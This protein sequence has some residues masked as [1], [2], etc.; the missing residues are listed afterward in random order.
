MPDMR[1]HLCRVWLSLGEGVS[2]KARA[3]ILTSF[4][5]YQAAFDRFPHGFDELVSAK[6]V[7]ELGRLK[8]AG[9]DRLAL[10][11]EELGIQTA[12]LGDEAEYP[13]MLSHIPDPPDVLFYRGRLSGGEE[14]A[15]AIVGSRR[16]T[17]YGRNQAYRIALELAQHGVTVISGLARGIDTAAH[18][19]ALDGKGR[20]IAVLGSGLSR[21]YPEENK[22]LA[23]EIVASGGA[24]VTELSPNTEPLAY[25]FP[26]RNRIV[27]G[28]SQAVLLVEAR[29]KSGTLI[30]VGHALDQGR[31]V[32]A[33]PGEVDAPGSVIP[34]RVIRT[35]GRLCTCAG[36]ILE[37][38]GW[39]EA[40]PTPPEQTRLPLPDLPPAQQ[41]TCRALQDEE[42][43]FDELIALTEL[44]TAELNTALTMLE[45]DGL[46]EPLPGRQFK[47]RRRPL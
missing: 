3:R 25:H 17:R 46:I 2:L 40:P 14:R 15:V 26:M 33:L 18:R 35:G 9:L 37:D 23:E 31:E 6:T 11:L 38:M 5:S 39:A 22:Q 12:F 4:G 27:S 20:T 43:G 10:R 19:G 24:V 41:A 34:H 44:S 30:T 13:G 36:D 7:E 42:K 47:L 1:E 16:E 45:L 21:I 32:F 29:E 28:L 8:A